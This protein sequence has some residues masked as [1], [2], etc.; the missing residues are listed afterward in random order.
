MVEISQNGAL[1]ADMVSVSFICELVRSNM[2][3][4]RSIILL[5]SVYCQPFRE[6]EGDV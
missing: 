4:P 2:P 3:S 5:P 1:S 6:L